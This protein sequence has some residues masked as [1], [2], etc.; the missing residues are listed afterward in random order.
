MINRK[1]LNYIVACLILIISLVIIKSKINVQNKLLD[2]L[3][4]I[5][6]VIISKDYLKVSIILS[7]IFLL[8][9]TNRN[10]KE[11]FISADEDDLEEKE[12]IEAS[13]IDND[14]NEDNEDN[15]GNDGN[16]DNHS[17]DDTEKE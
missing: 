4:L 13:K 15:D 11:T 16:D 10:V 9:K 5:L 17:N 6:I 7:F 2:L 8:I 12:M 3:T 1:D 14:D